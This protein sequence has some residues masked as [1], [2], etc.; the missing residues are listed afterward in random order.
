ADHE[1]SA[2]STSRV[3]VLGHEAVKRFA[4]LLFTILALRSIAR[5]HDGNGRSSR[6]RPSSRRHLLFG[7]ACL[8]DGPLLLRAGVQWISGKI[9]FWIVERA[10]SLRR[11]G[12]N[13]AARS[14]GHQ[15]RTFGRAGLAGR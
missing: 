8:P 11:A 6:A 12:H 15:T 5:I 10:R 14:V 9:P 13:R 4:V 7:A 2:G 1:R 3:G